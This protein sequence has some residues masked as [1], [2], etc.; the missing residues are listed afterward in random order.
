MIGTYSFFPALV[1]T[2]RAYSEGVH[3]DTGAGLFHL[4]MEHVLDDG[5]GCCLEEQLL[6]GLR[7]AIVVGGGQNEATGLWGKRTH[8]TLHF[9]YHE[10]KLFQ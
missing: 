4:I 3:V 2:D 1:K 9:D 7:Q 6:L 5:S 8:F 10:Y